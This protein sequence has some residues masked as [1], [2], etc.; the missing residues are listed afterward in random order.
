MA[1]PRDGDGHTFGCHLSALLKVWVALA[2]SELM[3]Y[4][5][6][7]TEEG[8]AMAHPSSEVGAAMARSLAPVLL[9][10]TGTRGR[11]TLPWLCPPVTDECCNG[12][13]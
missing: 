6:S 7:S 13:L 11:P 5:T 4:G 12:A 3:R 8:C 1:L 9:W 2:P 10:H